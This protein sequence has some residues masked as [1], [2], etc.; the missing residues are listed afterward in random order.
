LK[1][2]L[3]E[4]RSILAHSSVSFSSQL[5]DSIAFTPVVKQNII[6]EEWGRGKMITLWQPVRRACTGQG[7]ENILPGHAFLVIQFLI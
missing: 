6:A 2:H 1:K 7:R 5:T 3:K 4:E